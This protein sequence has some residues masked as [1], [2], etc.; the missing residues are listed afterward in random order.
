MCLAKAFIKHEESDELILNNIVSLEV[1]DKELTFT[2]L[3]E[4]T[5]TIEASIS[6]IDFLHGSIILKERG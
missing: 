5:K 1:S 6:S 3:L 4:E 2:T